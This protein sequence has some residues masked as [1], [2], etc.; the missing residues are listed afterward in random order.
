MVSTR[1]GYMGGS[2]SHSPTY[3]S[4]G[5]YTETTQAVFDPTVT[6]Y[7]NLLREFFD[8]HS[9][10]SRSSPQYA[11]IIFPHNAAQRASAEAALAAFEKESG[12]RVAT[13]IR[14]ATRFFT[15]EFYHGKYYIQRYTEICDALL[16]L[17]GLPRL[18][19]LTTDQLSNSEALTKFNGFVGSNGT[20]ADLEAALRKFKVDSSL[21]ADLRRICRV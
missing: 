20:K 5:D 16:E 9:P 11:S 18:D 1:V 10:F 19:S 17:E 8:G 14:D 3:R 4:I 21:E 13:V 6:S 7:D 2:A 15:A 12:R